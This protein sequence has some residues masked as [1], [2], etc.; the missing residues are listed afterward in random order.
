MH[1][2]ATALG[3]TRRTVRVTLRYSTDTIISLRHKSS[4]A[5]NEME[6]GNEIKCCYSCICYCC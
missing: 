1:Y 5:I 2:K 3:K 6:N 4:N